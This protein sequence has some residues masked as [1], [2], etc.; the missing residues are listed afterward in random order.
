MARKSTR[1]GTQAARKK[2]TVPMSEKADRHA[3][4]EQA[5]QCAEAE[6]DFV[7]ETFEKLRG[8][9]ATWLRED[10]CGTANTACE[11]VRRGPNNRAIGVDLDSEVQQW[12]E[13]HHLAALGPPVDPRRA[14]RGCVGLREWPLA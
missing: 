12:G 8:H 10:F 1:S 7:D 3:L 5:V 13:N 2:Q 4:Y 9:K 11:W 6:I 14:G